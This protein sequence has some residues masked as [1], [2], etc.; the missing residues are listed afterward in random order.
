MHHH[1]SEPSRTA[2]VCIAAG[3]VIVSMAD[4]KAQ[5]RVDYADDDTYIAELCAAATSLMDGADGWLKRALRTQRWR[6]VLPRF[7]HHWR[8][9]PSPLYQRWPTRIELPLPPLQSIQSITYI[10][11]SGMAQTLPPAGYRQV[12]CGTEPS[13]LV[14]AI[15]ASWP[16]IYGGIPDAVKIEFTAGYGTAATNV[17]AAITA[18]AKLLIGRWYEDRTPPDV[19]SGVTEPPNFVRDLIFNFR[20]VR[21]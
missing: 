3:A 4:A 19:A 18:A 16:A 7:E 5:A 21:L 8:R 2:L 9:F 13:F 15:G 6:L 10:D 12:D 1:A 20:I 14:P 11:G 17:P